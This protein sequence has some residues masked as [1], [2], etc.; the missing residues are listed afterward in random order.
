MTSIQP[1]SG[2]KQTAIYML[3]AVLMM[4]ISREMIKDLSTSKELPE[5]MNSNVLRQTLEQMDRF[6][7]EVRRTVGKTNTYLDQVPQGD[8]VI[9]S[10]NVLDVLNRIGMEESQAIYD[11]FLGMVVDL[12]DSVFYAQKN[13][14]SIYFNKYKAF[15]QLVS[16]EL[17]SDVNHQRGQLHFHQGELFLRTTPAIHEPKIEE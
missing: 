15:F 9:D 12:L 16:E 13:R 14:K 5:G 3:Q 17:R 11:E 1:L 4:N 10:L 2:V 6:I 8:K 7:R